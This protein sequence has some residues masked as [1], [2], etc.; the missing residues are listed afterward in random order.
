[1][2][3]LLGF[4]VL[5]YRIMWDNWGHTGDIGDKTRFVLVWMKKSR[6]NSG[7]S[8]RKLVIIYKDNYLII[9][10][11]LRAEILMLTS[12]F[13]WNQNWEIV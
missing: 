11:T 5:G 1:M 13:V 3:K 9:P 2:K 8:Y 4:L 7:K 12:Q 10:I 6:A